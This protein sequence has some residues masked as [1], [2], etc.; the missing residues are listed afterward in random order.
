MGKSRAAGCSTSLAACRQR[1]SLSGASSQVFQ[2]QLQE[3]A[4]A[5]RAWAWE[6]GPESVALVSQ[7][8]PRG[9][10]SRQAQPAH[11]GCGRGAQVGDLAALL[12]AA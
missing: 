11:R 4:S 12:Q 2:E 3:Q 7:A 10:A 5:E 6:V 8:R 9:A 1:F